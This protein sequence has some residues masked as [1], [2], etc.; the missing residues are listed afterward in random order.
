MSLSASGLVILRERVF[1]D[2]ESPTKRTITD[3]ITL[4]NSS[5]SEIPSIFILK[6]EFMLGLKIYDENNQELAFH[7][8]QLTKDL[9]KELKEDKELLDEINTQKSFIIWIRLPEEENRRA[10]GASAFR[11]RREMRRIHSPR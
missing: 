5:S 2:H 10:P 3:E 1:F 4:L 8:N 11:A 9:I 7:T 6:T